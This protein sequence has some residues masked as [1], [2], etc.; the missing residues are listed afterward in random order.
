MST[1]YFVTKNYTY[2]Y[3]CDVIFLLFE[4]EFGNIMFVV[5]YTPKGLPRGLV[6]HVNLVTMMSHYACAIGCGIGI[7]NIRSTYH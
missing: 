2:N 1:L 4:I 6:F 5:L 7:R 3:N